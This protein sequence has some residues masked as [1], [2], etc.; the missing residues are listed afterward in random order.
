MD[1]DAVRSVLEHV[2]AFLA[3]KGEESAARIRTYQDA[4]RAELARSFLSLE[5]GERPYERG[6]GSNP[7]KLAALHSI[8]P[9]RGRSAGS[10]GQR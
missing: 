6:T 7:D 10:R 8:I 3:L 9:R 4:A 2:A 1:K 5:P